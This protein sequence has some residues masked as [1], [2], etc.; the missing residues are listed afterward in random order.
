VDD[1]G[2]ENIFLGSKINKNQ[3]KNAKIVLK[4]S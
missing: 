1:E 2:G 3:G 4:K